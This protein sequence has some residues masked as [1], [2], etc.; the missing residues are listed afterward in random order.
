MSETIAVLFI[1]FVL[2]VFGILFY[3]KY[4]QAA[5]K[6]KQEEILGARAIETTLKALF[7]PELMCTKGE[8]EPEDNCFD[9]LKL[10]VLN[11]TLSKYGDDYY[12]DVFS[13][14]RIYVQ[15]VYP[16][17]K[18]WLLY[19]KVKPDA[20]MEEPS[21]FVITLKDETSGETEAQHHFGYVAV[22]VYS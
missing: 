11:E 14:A 20:V 15:E 9:M 8:A 4:Q 2:I 18:T 6:E 13:Y 1:F 17:E 5:F 12:F 16:E 3:S 19:D 21:Y 22:V 10:Q 7:L